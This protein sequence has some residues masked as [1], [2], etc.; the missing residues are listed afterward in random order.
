MQTAPI[1]GCLVFCI[2]KEKAF[3][4]KGYRV[5][6]IQPRFWTKKV[7]FL[8][9]R[10]RNMPSTLRNLSKKSTFRRVEGTFFEDYALNKS[11][12]VMIF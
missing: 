2:K 4:G 10:N 3:F 6:E 7:F 9:F 1:C 12:K 8:L 5:F 11:S